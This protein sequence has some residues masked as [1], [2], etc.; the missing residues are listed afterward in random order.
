MVGYRW[1]YKVKHVAD[2]S[3]EKYK[4]CFVAKGFSQKEGEDYEETFA[5]MA[6]YTYIRVVIS[7]TIEM[8][9]KL[10]RLDVKTNF[11]NGSIKE[12][13]YIEHLE[14]FKVCGR[15]SCVD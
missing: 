4:P 11:L 6:R 15:E 1:I 14:G 8:G 10:Q 2:G 7:I 5:L 12:E 13:V 3:V 9:W